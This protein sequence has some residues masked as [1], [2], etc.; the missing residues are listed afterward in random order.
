MRASDGGYEAQ[1]SV[2]MS[3]IWRHR[4]DD[5]QPEL[6]AQMPHRRDARPE[7]GTAELRRRVKQTLFGGGRGI[8]THETFLPTS[9]QDWL[10]R[11][12]GQPSMPGTTEQASI[13]T[14]P[15]PPRTL[16]NARRA[17][18]GTHPV[19][20]RTSEGR[21]P[22]RRRARMPSPRWPRPARRRA[23]GPWRRRGRVRRPR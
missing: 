12:L 23:P 21:R 20:V 5:R 2:T 22:G 6:R 7:C 16:R 10:H 17:P 11:P 14:D 19:S 15:H 18:R 3:R 8:R 13:L 9:F 4:L 1:L